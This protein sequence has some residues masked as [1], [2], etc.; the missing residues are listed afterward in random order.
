MAFIPQNIVYLTLY[1]DLPTPSNHH[2]QS[3]SEKLMQGRI[4]KAVLTE[5][6]WQVLVQGYNNLMS[7]TNLKVSQRLSKSKSLFQIVGS[8]WCFATPLQDYDADQIQHQ[9]DVKSD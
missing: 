1:P 2:T 9:N 5:V 4:I 6:E 8:G 3:F 7:R